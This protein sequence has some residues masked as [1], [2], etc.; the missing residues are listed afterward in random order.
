[1]DSAAAAFTSGAPSH[2]MDFAS[3][4]QAA[5]AIRK[6]QV[7]SVELTRH[8]F[9]RIAFAELLA[10]EIGGFAPPPGYGS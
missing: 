7:S 2:E 10:Q 3:A 6:K 9:E 4:L 1:M 5:E 8:V